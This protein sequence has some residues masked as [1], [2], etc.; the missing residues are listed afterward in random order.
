MKLGWDEK[1]LHKY[2]CNGDIAKQVCSALR[3]DRIAR[4]GVWIREPKQSGAYGGN[5]F[6]WENVEGATA[7][8]MVKLIDWIDKALY[9]EI[10]KEGR[11]LN[12][13]EKAE[14]FESVIRRWNTGFQRLSR[15]RTEKYRKQFEEEAKV[16]NG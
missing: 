5:Y 11:I 13:R 12:C 6:Q 15:M 2:L 8:D 9:K 16:K 14:V 1:K 3:R 7:E 4:L 10:I